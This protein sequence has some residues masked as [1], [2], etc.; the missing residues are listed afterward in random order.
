MQKEKIGIGIIG[1]GWPGLNHSRAVLRTEHAE[2]RAACDLDEA[3]R[4]VYAEEFPGIILGNGYEEMLQNPD[5]DAVVVC[6][7]NFLHFP[8]SLAALQA[9]K[10]VLCEKPPTLTP[11]EI[12]LIREEARRRHLTYAFGRQFRFS[13]PMLAARQA[14]QDGRL[15]N[16]YYGTSKWLRLRGAP[17]GIGGWFTDKA[18]AGGGVVMDLGIHALD[19]AWFLAGCPRPLTVSASTGLYLGPEK[20]ADP[21][22]AVEDT[23]VALLRFEGGLTLHLEV[24]W[25]MN[26]AS[27]EPTPQGWTGLE[28]MN[29]VLHGDQAVLQT[30]PAKIFSPDPENE[31]HILAELLVPDPE[32]DPFPQAGNF[33]R[34][35]TDFIRAVRTGT[36]PVNSV[37]QAVELMQM[38]SALYE[39]GRLRREVFLGEAGIWQDSM[40]SAPD[41][42]SRR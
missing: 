16:L 4:Q 35:M 1:L 31:R 37:D 42:R 2:L 33:T 20:S 14:V 5:V 28:V 15:G 19:A 32:E 30:H 8:V 3:R 22:N 29:T 21:G 13:Q 11:Q 12:L 17:Y 36:P 41:S 9:G 25:A 34:Q 40:S 7:P 23:G 26:L 6:L 38:L 18:R 24:A 27:D 10:H 39:S